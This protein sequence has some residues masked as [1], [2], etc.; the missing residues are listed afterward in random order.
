[1][2]D[3]NIAGGWATVGCLTLEALLVIWGVFRYFSKIDHKLNKLDLDYDNINLRYEDL[4]EK[5][6]DIDQK[7]DDIREK[8]TSIE[9]QY[10]PN[11]GSSMRDA[12]N[13][14]ENKFAKL[15]GRFEQHVEET[16]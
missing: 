4:T 8:L 12:V 10:K 3:W 15:E 16:D 13:R 1:M 11:G 9:L 14:I 6:N 2:I 7:Y 5:Y